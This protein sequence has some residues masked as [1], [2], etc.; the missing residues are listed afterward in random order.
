MYE[1]PSETAYGVPTPGPSARATPDNEAIAT[2]AIAH[3]SL[4]LGTGTPP[5]PW[6]GPLRLLLRL[7]AYDPDRDRVRGL[8]KCAAVGVDEVGERVA[9]VA[10]VGPDARLRRGAEQPQFRT[11]LGQPVRERVER[12]LLRQRAVEVAE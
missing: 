9:Q 1:S 11:L 8:C 2:N 7:S 12:V 6:D 3:D 5:L 4:T 10:L